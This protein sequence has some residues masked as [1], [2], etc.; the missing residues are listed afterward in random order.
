MAH[1]LRL[2]S[3]ESALAM[4]QANMVKAALLKENP[5]LD[6]EI[7]GISTQGDDD[8]TSPLSEIGGKGVFIKTLE[9]ALLENKID[10]AVHS[11]KDVT[12]Y[13]PDDLILSGFLKPEAIEDVLIAPKE[14][15]ITSLD[16]IPKNATIGTGS[17]RRR[18]LLKSLR[19]D[20]KTIELR[21]NIETRIQKCQSGDCDAILLSKVGLLRMGWKSKII[22][23]LDP[24][25]FVPA[26][27]Q[28][29]IA[30][31]TRKDDALSESYAQMISDTHQ[32]TISRIE[33]EILTELGLDC[34]F[35]FGL[36]TEFDGNRF[37]LTA[38]WSDM[39]YKKRKKETVHFLKQDQASVVEALIKTIKDDFNAWGV[40]G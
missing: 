30:L 40:Y 20:L 11:L 1:R 5:N 19:P 21:G 15:G 26:P 37:A 10:I 14:S 17:L 29:V 8:K 39:D 34:R 24:F 23:T 2:G 9:V 35:P 27:G 28:G 6:I 4:K 36:Y 38:F 18:A 16:A 3:R 32:T 22:E 13:S 25:M 7:I 31:Q 33:M 12:S